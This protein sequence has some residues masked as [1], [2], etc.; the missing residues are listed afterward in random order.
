MFVWTG[1]GRLAFWDG[2]AHATA[3]LSLPYRS[4]LC[5]W[6]DGL[7]FSRGFLRC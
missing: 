2:A 5:G 3:A 6:T 4:W 7:A 1:G